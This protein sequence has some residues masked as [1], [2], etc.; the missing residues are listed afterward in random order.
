M[1]IIA[2]FISMVFLYR[3]ISRALERT[4][5]VRFPNA[6]DL[7]VRNRTHD[8]TVPLRRSLFE[9]C[10]RATR[11]LERLH[12]RRH[13]RPRPLNL[14]DTSISQ[15]TETLGQ[16]LDYVSPMIVMHSLA[17]AKQR[18]GLPDVR[19][20]P[21]RQAFRSYARSSRNSARK[22]S[23]RRFRPERS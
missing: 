15:E 11:L 16:S 22:P 3:I 20:R 12:V 19:F 4:V 17:E 23:V 2:A 6:T 18:A 21:W 13:L 10:T 14:D 9:C 5:Y 7:R 8:R 1:L